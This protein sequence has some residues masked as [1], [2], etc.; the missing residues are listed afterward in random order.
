MDPCRCP[1]A[2][3]DDDMDACRTCAGVWAVDFGMPGA[4]IFDHHLDC[5]VPP[6]APTVV[7]A[8]RVAEA[9]GGDS[10]GSSC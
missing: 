6:V 4:A 9:A 8:L 2:T 7:V 1:V 3:L 5:A 10:V